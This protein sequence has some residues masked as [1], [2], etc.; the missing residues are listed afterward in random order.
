VPSPPDVKGRQIH[1]PTWHGDMT[2]SWSSGPAEDVV[3]G[4]RV[5]LGNGEIVQVS[6]IE[7]G[8][9]GM[10]TMLAFIEDTP[11]R[12]FKAPV[13]KGAIIEIERDT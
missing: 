13:P 6:K 2:K 3:I 7:D 8:F 10:D 9:M 11:E 12:W 5:R 1:D 4:E